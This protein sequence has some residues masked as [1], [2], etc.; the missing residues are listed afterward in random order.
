MKSYCLKSLVKFGLAS[1]VI[2]SLA[3]LTTVY[4][5][6]TVVPNLTLDAP[7][8]GIALSHTPNGSAFQRASDGKTW[9][10]RPNGAFNIPGAPF[11]TVQ[12]LRYDPD[13]LIYANV[14]VQNVTAVPQTY[15]FG[16][17][18]P[19]V[20]AAPNQ[21]RGSIDTS[22]IGTD[23]QISAVSGFSIY[24]AQIDFSTVKT[25][26]D[27]PFSLSTP[28]AAASSSD[29]FGFD[30]N[31]VAVNNS[32]GVLLRFT[33]S[34][35]DV[36]AIISDFEVVVPEPTSFSLVLLGAGLVLRCRKK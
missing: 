11:V 4:A 20:W 31:N 30:L 18:I 1:A 36:A 5:Q 2:F 24:S 21:I 33:L 22:I 23:G 14:L 15:T 10:L 27:D 29:S 13:P 32:I 26:Q 19:T 12:D 9:E 35:G 8:L 28:Q 17:S 6:P 3:S 7:G 25:M 34:P 16:F